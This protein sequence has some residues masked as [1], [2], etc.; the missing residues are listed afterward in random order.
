MAVI[1]MAQPSTRRVA[2]SSTSVIIV[3]MIM[4]AGVRSST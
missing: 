2:S 3:P 1:G 4:S